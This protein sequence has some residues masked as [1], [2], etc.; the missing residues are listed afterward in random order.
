MLVSASAPKPSMG[1]VLLE[2][3]PTPHLTV[4]LCCPLDPG[5]HRADPRPGGL[6]GD[7]SGHD[8]R[9]VLEAAQ[10]PLQP[11][12]HGAGGLPPLHHHHRHDAGTHA[13]T[14]VDRDP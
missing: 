8:G 7:G 9:G 13:I 11:G 1:Q 2:P 3:Q 10:R 5:D 6:Q 12:G 4:D 14:L